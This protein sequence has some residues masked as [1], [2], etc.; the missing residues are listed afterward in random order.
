MRRVQDVMQKKM[1]NV[2]ERLKNTIIFI[3]IAWQQMYQASRALTTFVNIIMTM[4][5][6][7][8]YIHVLIKNIFNTFTLHCFLTL[9]NNY[10]RIVKFNI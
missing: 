9:Y 10:N 5:Q 4:P 8:L 7:V 1:G 3:L 2:K 6:I